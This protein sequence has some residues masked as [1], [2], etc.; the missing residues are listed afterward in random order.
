MNKLTQNTTTINHG[1]DIVFYDYLSNEQSICGTITEPKNN[2]TITHMCNNTRKRSSKNMILMT[3]TF[4]FLL[5]F[6]FNNPQ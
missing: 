4:L 1:R 3:I 2:Q 5:A 6:L